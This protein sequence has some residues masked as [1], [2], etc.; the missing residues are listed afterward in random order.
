MKQMERFVAAILAAGLVLGAASAASAASVPQTLTHQGRLFDKDGKATNGAVQITFNIYNADND[1][2]PAWSESLDVTTEDGYFSVSLGEATPLTGVFDGSVKYLG[3]TVGSDAEM[4]PR[5]PIQS[6]PY[7][8]IAGDAIGDIH[9]TS[10]TVGGTKVIDA[11]GTW[12]GSP[13]NL[14][15]PQGPQ[16]AQ[17]PAGPQGPIGP[18]GAMGAMGLKGDPGATGATGPQGPK[19]DP[20]MTGATGA[21]GAQGPQ[22]PTGVVATALFS[23]AVVTINGSSAAW[24]FAGGTATVTTTATQRLTGAAEAPMGLGVGATP[25]KGRVG[26]CYQ[27]SVNGGAVINFS[28]GNYSIHQFNVGRLPYSAAG[29]VLPGAGTWKVGLCVFNNNLAPLSDNDYSN[30]FVQVTN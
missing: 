6:V 23:G 3:I 11:T 9:P 5:S 22:G 14:V 7:A 20:G 17:G 21:T 13:T 15:G 16:G 26:I 19:G 4:T 27:D 1:P 30:G 24:V 18:M 12:V 29:T 28:G 8:M 2:T 10:V 25:Q